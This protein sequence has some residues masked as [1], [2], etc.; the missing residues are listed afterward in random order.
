MYISSTK[1]PSCLH[2]VVRIHLNVSS[3]FWGS[4]ESS[5]EAEREAK[6]VGRAQVGGPFT[7]TTHRNQP[8]SEL[9]LLDKWSLLY[10][11]FTN[12]PDICPA[13]LDKMTAIVDTLGTSPTT[14]SQCA[15]R[16]ST[17]RRVTVFKSNR[18]SYPLTLRETLYLRLRATWATFTLASL[19]SPEPMTASRPSAK[20]TESTSLL[21]QTLTPKAITWSIIRY[22]CI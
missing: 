10:F 6:Q 1:K 5:P 3:F 13:E 11:G 2:S 17:Q 4:T 16:N 7:L 18:C 22:S 19:A 15:V 8:F 12:C 14:Y 21:P 20:P 9:D